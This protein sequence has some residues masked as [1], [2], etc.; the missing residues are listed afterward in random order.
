M[1]RN[2]PDKKRVRKTPPEKMPSYQVSW[3]PPVLELLDSEAELLGYG[4]RGRKVLLGQIIRWHM[5]RVPRPHR[6]NNAPPIKWNP[7]RKDMKEVKFGLW[8]SPEEKEWLKV[9]SRACG[10]CPISALTS[11]MFLAWLDLLPS[12]YPDESPPAEASA[13]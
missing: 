13:E 1:V 2:F 6:A 7:K 11:M 8:V 3:D 4:R 5:G 12:F 9:R 10:S